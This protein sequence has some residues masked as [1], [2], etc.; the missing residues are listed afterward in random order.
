MDRLV[1]VT[2]QLASEE[3]LKSHSLWLSPTE[4]G[5]VAASLGPKLDET[6]DELEKLLF[7]STLLLVPP[8]PVFPSFSPLFPSTISLP[9]LLLPFFLPVH[10]F[11]SPPFTF[12]FS[13]PNFRP[14]PHPL[15]L[16]LLHLSA[17]FYR[18]LIP[19]F[20]FGFTIFSLFAPFGPRKGEEKKER[21]R[22]FVKCAS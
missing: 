17:F 3:A 9:L 13:S 12:L 16:P 4:V 20:Q 18:H 7:E 11:P 8:S 19:C 5:Q 21:R 1:E 10:R 22:I 6:R 14:V 15:S 2:V